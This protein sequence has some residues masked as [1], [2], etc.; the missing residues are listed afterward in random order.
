[1]TAA[2]TPTRPGFPSSSNR[3]DDEVPKPETPPTEGES[4][5]E[6]LL[7]SLPLF[8]VGALCLA[9]AIE[10]YSTGATTPSGTNG[11]VHLYPWAL[12]FALAVTGIAAGVFVWFLEEEPAAPAEVAEA[13]SEPRE[14][15]PEWDESA[16]EPEKPLYIRPRTWERYPLSPAEAGFESVPPDA[17]LNQIDEIEESLRKKPRKDE[18]D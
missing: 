10:L 12:F 1:M 15:A 14:E 4:W 13:V 5:Q 16:L 18:A 7:G 17:V 6:K 11:S 9:I 2:L 8:V 3:V